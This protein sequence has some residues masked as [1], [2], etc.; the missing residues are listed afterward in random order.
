MNPTTCPFCVST[1]VFALPRV[2]P[3]LR[4]WHQCRDCERL[5]IVAQE[6]TAIPEPATKK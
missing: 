5:F 4:P 2:S 6:P 1:N 3:S